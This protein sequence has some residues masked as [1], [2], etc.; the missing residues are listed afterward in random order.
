MFDFCKLE[1]YQKAKTFCILVSKFLATGKF[2]KTTKDQLRRASFSIMLNIAEGS[3]RFSNK[4]RK[5]FM[6]IARG[7]A[8]ESA[9]IMEY[10][11]DTSEVQKDVLED[12]TDK[13]E[14]ISKMLFSLIQ[15][16]DSKS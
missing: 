15:N 14:Q 10:L 2:D 12:F 8:F 4:D 13:L 5:N 16:L 1:V 11:L 3:S 9:A 6:I 7:S